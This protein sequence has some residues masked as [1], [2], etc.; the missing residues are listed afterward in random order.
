MI[1]A[2]LK[3]KMPD[4][5]VKD[6]GI[7]YPSPIRFKGCMPHGESGGRGLVEIHGDPLIAERIIEEIRN[8]PNVCKV[9]VSSFGEGKISGS[10]ITNQCVACRAL[11]GSECFLTHA[12]SERDGAVEWNLVTGSNTTL[13]S[14]IEKLRDSGCEV[15]INSITRITG[16]DVVTRRQEEIIKE[17]FDR[18]YY[19]YPRKT[20][21][22]DLA[23]VFNISPSTLGEI[24][25][26][27]ERNI[28]EAFFE[29]KTE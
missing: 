19:D 12:R 24:L 20:T 11:T 15:E 25:Q 13:S 7:K 29:G 21:I 26:R 5:W 18:G 4:S 14:L 8:H 3:V 9:D 2:S 1:E 10:I 28:I 23:R 6:I 17:A 22:R 16:Q 27:G